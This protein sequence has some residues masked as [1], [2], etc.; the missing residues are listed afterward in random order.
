MA[1]MASPFGRFFMNRMILAL[2]V[3]AFGAM[4]AFAQ[5]PAQAVTDAVTRAATE[6]AAK[7]AV[8]VI[9]QSVGNQSEGGG[10]AKAIPQEKGKAKKAANYGRSLDH[11]Q[12]GEHKKQ[13]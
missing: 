8:D 13:R 5:S 4:P 6:S 7:A 2:G 10:G 3:A 9:N 1:A 11:R 12:D